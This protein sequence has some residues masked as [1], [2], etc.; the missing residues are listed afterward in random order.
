MA[1]AIEQEA[2]RVASAVIAEGGHADITQR[3]LDLVISTSERQR[4]AAVEIQ[5]IDRS[6]FEDWNPANGEQPG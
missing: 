4:K 3:V 1:T 5:K 2:E 6:L